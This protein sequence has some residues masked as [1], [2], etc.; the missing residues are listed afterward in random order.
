MISLLLSISLS[1]YAPAEAQ[2]LFVEAND[3]YYAKDF[4][5]AKDKYSKLLKAGLI[6]SDVYFNLGT[7]H[8]AAGEL[9]P[10]VLFL[11]RAKRA[12]TDDDIEANLSVAKERQADHVVG[13]EIEKPFAQRLA[14]VLPEIPVTIAF[15]AL[16]LVGFIFVWMRL[17][18]GRGLFTVLAA[19]CLFLALGAGTALGIQQYAHE[20]IVESVV[21]SPSAQAIDH[22]G[23]NSKVLFEVHAGL[24]VRVMETYDT[25]ARIRLPNA[26]EGW[27]PASALE[28]L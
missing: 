20:S 6:G 18:S 23:N 22:P 11:E 21:M 19:L 9:G 10:A 15:L 27:V 5:T 26:L 17:A 1:Q 16:W 28:N 13:D 14:A 25:Y 8:L 2:A 12:G 4:S 24:L 3:A 7:T